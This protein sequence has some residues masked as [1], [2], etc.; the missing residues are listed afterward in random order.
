MQLFLIIYFYMF[1][2][3]TSLQQY[4]LTIPEAEMYS[5]LLLMMG[6]GTA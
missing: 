6:G 4:W 2:H 5:Y 1:S 3:D